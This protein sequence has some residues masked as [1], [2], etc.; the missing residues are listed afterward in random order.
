MYSIF[1]RRGERTFRFTRKP[2]TF[3][4]KRPSAGDDDSPP[5]P[6]CGTSTRWNGAAPIGGYGWAAATVDPLGGDRGWNLYRLEMQDRVPHKSVETN[7]FG[8]GG[9]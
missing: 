5:D 2:E 3:L 1:G 9:V 8:E 6:E 4:E 7:V